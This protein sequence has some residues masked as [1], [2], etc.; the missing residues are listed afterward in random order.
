MKCVLIASMFLA[1]AVL[2]QE[3]SYIRKLPADRLRDFP[4]MCF[5]S[6]IC[7]VF[8]VGGTWPLRP[9]C[10]NAT[11]VQEGE[12]LLEVVQ[13]CARAKPN[14]DCT[15]NPI[16]PKQELFFPACCPTF[17]CKEGATIAYYTQAENEDL[18]KQALAAAS[19]TTPAPVAAPAK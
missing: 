16:D 19:S 12:Q 13:E 9:F 3:N 7:K 6:T 5:G 8:N 10:G 1:V 15:E 17:T 11:C 4:G 2:A 18:I 14:P